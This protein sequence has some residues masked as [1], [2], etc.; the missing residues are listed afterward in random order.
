MKLSTIPYIAATTVITVIALAVPAQ[1]DSIAVTYS[2]TGTGT[3]QSAT[4]TT[5]TLAAVANGSVLSGNPGLNAAWNPVTY[6]DE[7]VLDL[8]TN[9]LNGNFTLT[10]AGGDTFNWEHLRRRYCPRYK[11]NSD[12][13]L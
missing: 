1:A 6:S 4:D 12:R 10:F 9:L 5:L 3:V 11:R 7:S 13:S 2:F 8:T